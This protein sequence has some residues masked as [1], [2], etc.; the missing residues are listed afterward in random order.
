MRPWRKGVNGN[1]AR[2][3]GRSREKWEMRLERVS[4]IN[5]CLTKG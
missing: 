3:Q 2:E 1:W 5:R 4:G